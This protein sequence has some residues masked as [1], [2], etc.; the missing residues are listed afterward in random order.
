M[1]VWCVFMRYLLCRHRITSEIIIFGLGLL[2]CEVSTTD[3]TAMTQYW[4]FKR[5]YLLHV[6]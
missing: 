6:A 2:L 5:Y 3:T 4:N 1:E